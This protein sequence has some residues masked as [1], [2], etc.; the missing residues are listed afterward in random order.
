MLT[1]LTGA[2]LRFGSD[3]GVVFLPLVR[4]LG[5][6]EL[7]V[8]EAV[9]DT[10]LLDGSAGTEVEGRGLVIAYVCT[11]LIPDEITNERYFTNYTY[12][13]L[14]SCDKFQPSVFISSHTTFR[15]FLSVCYIYTTISIQC[16]IKQRCKQLQMAASITN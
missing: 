3:G 8:E 6:L 4:V 15:Q 14:G 12:F 10:G 9:R 5:E 11:E 16:P 13:I 1:G 7:L 2:A